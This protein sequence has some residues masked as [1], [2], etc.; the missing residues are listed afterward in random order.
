MAI[1]FAPF[2]DE[3]DLANADLLVDA[4]P[5]LGDGL[6]LSN[7]ATNGCYLLCGFYSALK[8]GVCGHKSTTMHVGCIAFAQV[9]DL[10]SVT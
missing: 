2:V 4:R 9:C 3:L 7:G 1:D 8:S 5:I 10:C 6:R